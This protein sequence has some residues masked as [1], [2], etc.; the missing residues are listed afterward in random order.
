[1]LRWLHLT[2]DEDFVPPLLQALQHA[3]QQLHFATLGP[4]LLRGRVGD[5]A[6]KGALD[7]VRVV[8]VL[9]HLHQDVVQL[10]DADVGS[11]PGLGHGCHRLLHHHHR[12][13]CKEEDRAGQ[14][15]GAGPM[16]T[17]AGQDKAGPG[18]GACTSWIESAGYH[19]VNNFNICMMK[20]TLP[21][22]VVRFGLQGGP[23]TGCI[24]CMCQHLGFEKTR[25]VC[26]RHLIHLHA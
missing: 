10:G 6:I 3:L 15:I 16:H 5:A 19:D 8:A 4:D 1:M 18:P 9:A 24:S 20:K 23:K 11:P 17:R 12:D 7:E 21:R 13:T 2:E 22:S 25:V 26:W 14:P